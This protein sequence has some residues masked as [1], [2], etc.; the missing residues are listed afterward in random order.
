MASFQECPARWNL[1]HAG[2]TEEN[3]EEEE[4]NEFQERG[5]AV[6][7]ACEYVLRGIM[8]PNLVEHW[9][10][11]DN[12]LKRRG[13]PTAERQN[14]HDYCCDLKERL[15]DE[16]RWKLIAVEERFER[17]MVPGAP[18][19]K[20]TPDAT[21]FDHLRQCYVIQDHKTNRRWEDADVWAGRL[22]P[23]TY[24]WA[25]RSLTPDFPIDFEIGY[26][27]LGGSLRWTTDPAEDE[28]LVKEFADLWAE[29]GVY[30]R[31]GEW[32][33]RVNNWCSSCPLLSGC[34]AATD[35]VASVASATELAELGLLLLERLNH[36][37]AAIKIAEALEERAK[38]EVRAAVECAGGALREGQWLALLQARTKREASFHITH[39]VW[40][41][42]PV[43]PLEEEKMRVAEDEVFA[44]RLGALDRVLKQVP[45]LAAR[46]RAV[47]AIEDVPQEPA[48]VVR[49]ARPG[50]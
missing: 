36:L 38:A 11:E 30:G 12:R 44:V 13:V 37:R 25:R 43:S 17:A 47:E 1:E 2:R 8:D 19:I 31:T 49:L 29:L 50:E 33:E 7:Q 14:A 34:H 5:R 22:Q 39:H 40:T 48:L 16:E 42:T 20:G 3:G 4:G 15:D 46:V 32:P 45:A 28:R 35:L 23:R 18:P 21:W 27:N 26:V 6:H 10:A 9:E 24:A 41:D